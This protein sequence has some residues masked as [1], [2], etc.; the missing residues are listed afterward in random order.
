VPN[1][2]DV[3]D[4]AADEA[5]VVVGL[6]AGAVVPLLPVQDDNTSATSVSETR[7]DLFI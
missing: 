3:A 7:T 2:T 6:F 1:F 4:P 5:A